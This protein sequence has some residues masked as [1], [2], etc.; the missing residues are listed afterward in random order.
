MA[1][2]RND[3]I[4]VAN[5]GD[6]RCVV[7]EGSGLEDEKEIILKAGGF[8]H[9]GPVNG[10]L[11]LAR[12]I[13]LSPFEIFYVSVVN[14]LDQKLGLLRRPVYIFTSNICLQVEPSHEDEFIVIACDEVWNYINP[15][16]SVN[17]KAGP[18]KASNEK[19]VVNEGN[20]GET[21]DEPD[22]AE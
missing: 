10:S 21:I 5:A 18:E 11:N 3:Q 19:A 8:I 16:N 14:H 13:D 7:K 15:S 22:G 20:A 17:E 4:F 2:I 1:V 9:A 12:S 6:S